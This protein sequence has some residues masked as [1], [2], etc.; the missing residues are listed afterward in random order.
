MRL[1]DISRISFVILDLFTN[2]VMRPIRVKHDEFS[3]IQHLCNGIRNNLYDANINLLQTVFASYSDR[4][5][6]FMELPGEIPNRYV[7]CMLLYLK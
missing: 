2:Q 3:S 4:A 6:H 1:N 7:H 5:V